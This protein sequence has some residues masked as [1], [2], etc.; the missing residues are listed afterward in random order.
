MKLYLH[1]LLHTQPPDLLH[2]QE[3][4][5]AAFED[6]LV[7][8]SKLQP[9]KVLHAKQVWLVTGDLEQG[10]VKVQL[11]RGD[12]TACADCYVSGRLP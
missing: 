1:A 7:D 11:V 3:D 12:G 4:A 8:F 10:C 5:V 6:G 2:Q 9:G